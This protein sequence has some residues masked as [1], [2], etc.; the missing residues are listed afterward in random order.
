M[1]SGVFA[2][3]CDGPFLVL[4]QAMAPKTLILV[5]VHPRPPE[6]SVDLNL[7]AGLLIDV[8]SVWRVDCLPYLRK[9]GFQLGDQIWHLRNQIFLFVWVRYNVK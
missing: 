5:L 7:V 2:C 8:A 1:T 3:V 6:P 4:V 9:P